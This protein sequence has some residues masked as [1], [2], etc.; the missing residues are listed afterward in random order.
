MIDGKKG[1]MTIFVIIG[2]ALVLGIVIYF[3]VRGNV[4][5]V[6]GVSSDL[7]PV[8]DYYQECIRAETKA[9][10]DLAGSQGGYIELPEY[11]LPSEYSPFSSELNFLGF[12]VPY[13]YYIKGNGVIKEQPPSKATIENG[14]EGY[15]EER[16]G[17][18]N[19]DNFYLQ[20]YEIILG[21]SNVRVSISDE[22]IDVTVGCSLKVSKGSDSAT[23]KEHSIVIESKL[24]KFYNLAKEIYDAE[25]K[26]AVF[27]QYAVDVLRLYAPVDGVE[28]SC[29][30]KVWKTQEVMGE[31]RDAL[32][33]NMGAIKFK[34]NYYQLKSEVNKYF[35]VDAGESFDES[36]NIIYSQN[37]PSKI[38]INGDGASKDL[39]ITKPIG[40]QEG[41]G[42]MSFCYAP[43]HFIY[44]ISF[45]VIVQIYNNDEIFQFPII[46]IVDKN[47]A[48][49][50]QL[51][52]IEGDEGNFDLCEYM[53][54][55][56]EVNLYDSEL[57]PV[58]GQISY[59]CFNQRCE[60][61]KSVNGRFVGKAPGCLNGF[62]GVRG[63]GFGEK[64]VIYSS[65]KE[66][67]ADI[68][69][70]REYNV[71]IELKVG[72]KD[73]G[74]SELAIVSFTSEDK[75]VSTA[76]PDVKNVKLSE[77]NYEVSV[78][79]YGNSSITIQASTKR[80]CIERPKAGIAGWFGGTKEECFDIN[81]PQMKIEQ[82]L[83]GGGKGSAYLLAGQL[84]TGKIII[85]VD[86]LSTPKSL[87]DL[88][89][90]YA[91]FESS[92]VFVR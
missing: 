65:N 14:I 45:P 51:T 71:E 36:V 24:G 50:A 58:D 25:R 16:L 17:Q 18:C 52:E 21:R 30:G 75:S 78:Y 79:I 64:K 60:L 44:D 76:L 12:P 4:I 40:T 20:G 47:V 22:K 88:Q 9:A 72:G 59:E 48:R 85:D 53:T 84:E 81:V 70:D 49:E 3:L 92:G 2:I 56:I 54:Q 68:V 46:V 38:E 74:G 6:D 32:Q 31:L 67:F 11:S 91:S 39:L 10:V 55:D 13:W 63:E 90:N 73:V 87:E 7:K 27:E 37:M 80:E 43:Y 33:A 28:L 83:K 35:V 34:G 77:G 29:S 8:F 42:V 23:K 86:A 26:D 66:T 41:L 61:G 89:N 1:Q 69:L 15:L 62:I 82:A 5:E 19:F 57:T